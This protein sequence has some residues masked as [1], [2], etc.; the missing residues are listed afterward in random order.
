MLCLTGSLDG[1]PL[2]DGNDDARETRGDWRR[3]VYDALPAGDKAE[4]W[5]DGAGLHMVFGGMDL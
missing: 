2:G 3:A 5:L 4:L 1:A